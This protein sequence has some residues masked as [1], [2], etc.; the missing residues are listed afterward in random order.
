ML[1]IC[2]VPS[3]RSGRFCSATLKYLAGRSAG[4]W[5]A[6]AGGALPPI[7]VTTGVVA[8]AELLRPPP[9]LL[10]LRGAAGVSFFLPKPN[11]PPMPFFLSAAAAR[12]SS[13]FT[14]PAAAVAAAGFA[15]VGTEAAV[16]VDVTGAGAAPG[17]RMC[18][19]SSCS[20]SGRCARASFKCVD[21]C[22]FCSN[23]ERRS[24]AVFL[25]YKES[26][27][28]EHHDSMRSDR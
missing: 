6:P 19:C 18:F 25:F 20:L 14:A 13:F 1:G 9:L 23:S 17:A 24:T 10:L 11:M 27:A 28:Y 8:P 15:L 16:A 5:P 21:V 26:E 7:V 4:P 2:L 22:C 3:L 12:G